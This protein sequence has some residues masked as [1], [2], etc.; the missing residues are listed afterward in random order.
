MTDGNQ[1]L[2]PGT[3]CFLLGVGLG[4]VQAFFLSKPISWAGKSS[5]RLTRRGWPPWLGGF[6][7]LGLSY[8]LAR[9]LLSALG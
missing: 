3:V 9:C 1:T 7:S 6:P 2:A 8:V 4:R 5:V